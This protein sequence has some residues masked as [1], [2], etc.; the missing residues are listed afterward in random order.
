MSAGKVHWPPA[1]LDMACWATLQKTDKRTTGIWLR[2]NGYDHDSDVI[3]V[4]GLQPVME[5]LSCSREYH[6]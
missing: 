5:N 2:E 3:E 6:T 4:E 1:G